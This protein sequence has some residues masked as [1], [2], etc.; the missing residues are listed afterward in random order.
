MPFSV[1]TIN[2]RCLLGGAESIQRVR[3]EIY[4]LSG[5]LWW[6]VGEPGVEVLVYRADSSWWGKTM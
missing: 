1:Y 3:V 5:G 2:L 6:R 4:H